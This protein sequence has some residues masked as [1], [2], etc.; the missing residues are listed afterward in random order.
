MPG[1]STF[2]GQV[3]E[4]KPVKKNEKEPSGRRKIK[5]MS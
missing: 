5:N 4:E 2:N 1:M 3:Q